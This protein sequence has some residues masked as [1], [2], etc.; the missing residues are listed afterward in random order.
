[1]HTGYQPDCHYHRGMPLLLVPLLILGLVLLWALL[2]PLSLLQRY[3]HGKSRRR[4]IPWVAGAN[5]WALLVSLASFLIGAALA[6]RWLDDAFASACIGLAVGF[7]LGLLNLWTSRLEWQGH[8]LHVQPHALIA[9]LLTVLVAGRLALG[10]WQAWKYGFTLHPAVMD[11]P[12]LLRPDSLFAFG[13]L[14]LGHY[15]AWSWALRARLRHG[16][17]RLY[18]QI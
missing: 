4:V 3:R 7:A 17:R 8:H 12:W 13:G 5:A 1:M 9:L 6:Q 15:F 16:H 2:L 10:M 14:L 11:G 18:R